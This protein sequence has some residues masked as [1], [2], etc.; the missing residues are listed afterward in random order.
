[1]SNPVTL[2]PTF[3]ATV[4]GGDP[5]KVHTSISHLRANLTDACLSLK[6]TKLVV[7]GREV[8]SADGIGCCKA[9]KGLDMSN[10][11]LET[12]EESKSPAR[13]RTPVVSDR[14]LLQGVGE[15]K[16]LRHLNVSLN[17]LQDL[18]GLEGLPNLEG[19]I[20]CALSAAAHDHAFLAACL[21][22]SPRLPCLQSSTPARTKSLGSLAS[23]ASRPSKPSS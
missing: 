5:A 19:S 6:A 14:F 4:T 2:N 16:E 9:L 15:C 12:L 13:P 22:S 8:V 21:T 11:K 10:N 17:Q 3:I 23:K 7:K 1:M 20:D 18:N